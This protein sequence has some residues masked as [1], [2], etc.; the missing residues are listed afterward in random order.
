MASG[1]TYFVGAGHARPAADPVARRAPPERSRRTCSTKML[2]DAPIRLTK[3][4][5]NSIKGVPA[6]TEVL[7][8]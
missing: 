6:R 2:T 5:V 7:F 4:L 8:G 1:A 3:A